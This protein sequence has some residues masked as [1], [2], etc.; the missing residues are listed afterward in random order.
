MGKVLRV[1]ID[2]LSEPAATGTGGLVYLKNIARALCEVGSGSSE[3]VIFTSETNAHVFRDI[4]DKAKIFRSRWLSE[5]LPFRVFSQQV[6]LPFL[7]TKFSLDALLC[8]GNIV[9]VLGAPRPIVIVQNRLQYD[10]PVELGRIRRSYRRYLG[11]LSLIRAKKIITLSE[12]TSHYLGEALHVP[13][14]RRV[15]IP[16][17]VDHQLFFVRNGLSR[18]S[19]RH[20]DFLVVSELWPYKNHE[21]VFR[22][23]ARCCKNA[24]FSGRLVLVGG[25]WK[26]R[27][28]S[29]KRLATDLGIAGRVDFV[30]R[31]PHDQMPM[32]YAR[33]SALL[34][35][36]LAE[37]FPLPVLEAMACGV[38]VIASNR[39]SF[40]ELVGDAGTC[41]DPHDEKAWADAICRVMSDKEL[42]S[43]MIERGL[44]RARQYTWRAA[45]EK[46]LEV[47]YEAVQENG[48]G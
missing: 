16:S 25:D 42:R 18:E 31:V 30:G 40:P 32:V 33:S 45:G 15:V 37:C 38:P 28:Q 8:P 35:P 9:P 46:L 7:A 1:G 47:L 20:A 43:R 39:C 44:N 22:A 27:K 24:D 48:S 21:V 6:V 34:F 4:S 11:Y 13:E 2:G 41:I 14:N 17:G 29:L 3:I 36:S 19:S 5:R 10:L 26:N 23:L 12:D